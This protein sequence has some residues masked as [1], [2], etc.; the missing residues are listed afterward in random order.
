MHVIAFNGSPRKGGN[1]SHMIVHL[2]ATL[3]DEGI[4][5]EEIRIGG[6][7]LHGCTACGKCASE[8]PGRCTLTEDPVNEWIERMLA[9]DAIVL[10]SP[11]YFAN[12]T[13]EMKA[14][15]DRVGVVVRAGGQLLRRK[16][17]APVVV[18]RRGGAMQTYNALMAFFGISQMIVPMSSYWNM[19]FGLERGKVDEDAEAI[20][21][22]QDLGSNMAYVLKALEKTAS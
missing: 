13:P 10:A 8:H 1:T 3:Q 7:A 21:T 5:G 19:G 14:F 11:T 16:V 9:A 17:G 12:V 4:S 6:R 18:A 22:M 15:I 20:R 2:L